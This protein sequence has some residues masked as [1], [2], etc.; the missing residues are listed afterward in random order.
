MSDYFS[1]KDDQSF[2]MPNDDPSAPGGST[3]PPVSPASGGAPD[4]SG[5]G[6]T[7]PGNNAP[8]QDI[9]YFGI[10][11]VI[12]GVMVYTLYA[13]FFAGSP[14]VPAE[15]IQPVP[16]ETPAKQAATQSQPPAEMP[17]FG[18][19]QQ[20]SGQPS[21]S[22]TPV[23][24]TSVTTVPQPTPTSEKTSA[25]DTQKTAVSNSKLNAVVEENSVLSAAV[26]RLTDSKEKADQRMTDLESEVDELVATIDETKAQLAA[27]KKQ[28]AEQNAP[29]V[30][31]KEMTYHIQAVVEGR[32]WLQ[33]SA[34]ANITVKVG[35]ELKGYGVV[36]KIDAVNSVILTSS[37]KRIRV[38]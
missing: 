30:T 23:T 1:D 24:E 26:R 18:Q 4:E 6:S 3:P 38:N 5:F 31:K 27:L 32:A 14:S 12:I 16:V 34:G 7:T 37:G 13:M 20:S 19:N 11:A 17:R 2:D 35:D 10:L 33:S 29:K 15:Q 22:P 9:V 25:A 28:I 21:A 8:Q 36:T